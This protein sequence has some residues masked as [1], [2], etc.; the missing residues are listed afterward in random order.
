MFA[1]L[2]KKLNPSPASGSAG[3]HNLGGTPPR[4]CVNH[5]LTRGGTPPPQPENSPDLANVC[6]HLLQ[7]DSISPRGL[8]ERIYGWYAQVFHISIIAGWLPRGHLLVVAVGNTPNGVANG[9]SKMSL[10]FQGVF[11]FNDN[12]T[13]QS[14]AILFLHL[15]F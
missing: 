11:N 9:L 10:L 15:K 8:T 14:K 3:L 7:A 2:E 13:F 6:F 12:S 5:A 4:Q 1:F